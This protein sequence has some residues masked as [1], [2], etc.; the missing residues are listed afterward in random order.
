MH[1]VNHKN[2]LLIE[3]GEKLTLLDLPKQRTLEQKFSSV[4]EAVDQKKSTGFWD[5]GGVFQ[6]IEPF[7]IRQSL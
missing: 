6:G 4:S 1:L 7:E 2:S 5:L 3:G